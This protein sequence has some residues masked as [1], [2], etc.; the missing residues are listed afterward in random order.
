MAFRAGMSTAATTTG[1]ISTPRSP[2]S[3]FAWRARYTVA[4]TSRATMTPTPMYTF[5]L[6]LFLSEYS[7]STGMRS[8]RV[9]AT[10]AP[11][12]EPSALRASEVRVVGVGRD[13]GDGV[14]DDVVRG[15]GVDLEDGEADD[16][17]VLAAA[18]RGGDGE[19]HR[20]EVR[21]GLTVSVRAAGA[22]VE[23]VAALREA[24]RIDREVRERPAARRWRDRSRAERDRGDP[25]RGR[26][27]AAVGE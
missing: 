4:A 20:L 13:A 9:M 15:D 6:R 5:D 14:A 12:H 23:H 21:D 24:G 10:S 2:A 7:S 3:P 27:E 19:A 17:D 16:V 26:I 11:R 22:D 8:Y 1:R 25:Q 18:G